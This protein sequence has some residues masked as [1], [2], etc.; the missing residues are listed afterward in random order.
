VNLVIGRIGELSAERRHLNRDYEKVAVPLDI[1][2]LLRY[3][4][5]YQDPHHAAG[6]PIFDEESLADLL[7]DV[8]DGVLGWLW[9]RNRQSDCSSSARTLDD[10]VV[11]TRRGV[12]WLQFWLQFTPVRRR[13]PE[14]IRPGQDGL[15]PGR[16]AGERTHNPP[17][18]GSS[19]TRPTRQ[20]LN[21]DSKMIC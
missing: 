11:G 9:I 13:P 10:C 17:V 8:R 6:Q 3:M 18:V 1:P 15:G 5:G 16:T 7:D 14:F 12:S 21:K 19:P 20:N 4:R 2:G